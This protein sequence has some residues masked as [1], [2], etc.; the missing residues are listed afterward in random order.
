MKM[1]KFLLELTPLV[2]FFA[3]YKYMGLMEATIAL[4]ITTNRFIGDLLVYLQ[5]GCD[6]AACHCCACFGVWWFDAL[7]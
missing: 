5:K 6:D 3:V 2:I 1:V 4:M 7:F